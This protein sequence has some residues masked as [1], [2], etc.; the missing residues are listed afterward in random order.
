MNIKLNDGVT[1]EFQQGTA[2]LEMA[3]ELDGELYKN[4][5][6]AQ[7]D[8][9]LCSLYSPVESDCEV[10]ILT[11]E[12]EGGRWVLLAHSL[13]RYGPGGQAPVPR[14]QAGHR[15]GHGEWVLLRF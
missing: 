8:G 2:P 13:P 3:R 4:A 9:K 1:R 14:G 6:A 10:K 15:S 5:L 12:D 11:F 7:V